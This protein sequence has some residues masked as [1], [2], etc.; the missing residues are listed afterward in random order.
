MKFNLGLKIKKKHQIVFSVF[1]FAF[2]LE[3]ANF[4]LYRLTKQLS[5]GS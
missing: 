3:W 2:D 1:Y 4:E 5:Q